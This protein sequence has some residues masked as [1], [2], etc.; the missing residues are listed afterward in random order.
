MFWN[1]Y[2]DQGGLMRVLVDGMIDGQIESD[3]PSLE[4]RIQ[5]APWQ[6]PELTSFAVGETASGNTLNISVDDFNTASS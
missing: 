2:F 1:E 6:P 5:R 3:R 4:T